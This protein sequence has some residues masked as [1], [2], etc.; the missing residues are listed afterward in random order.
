MK[1]GFPAERIEFNGNNKTVSELE[2][3]VEY[4]IGRI[5]VDSL[6]EVSLLEKNL[7]RK[8]KKTVKILVPYYTGRKEQQPRL[9]RNRK[10]RI[11]SLVFLLTTML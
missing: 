7:R 3:A 4:G 8:E 6:Q 11:P 2:M 10:K 9:Y 1:A 5:I